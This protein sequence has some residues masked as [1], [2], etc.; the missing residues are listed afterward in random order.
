MSV[1]TEQI[2][3]FDPAFDTIRACAAL[4]VFISHIVIFMIMEKL[5]F[6]GQKY[7]VFETLAALSV[8]F[9][10]V[11]SGIL[12]G[13]ILLKQ[14]SGEHKNANV[15]IFLMRRWMRTLPVYYL[16]LAGYFLIFRISEFPLP[17]SWPLY[18]VFLQSP[19]YFNTSFFGVSW[20][21]CIEE[22]FYILF[23]VLVYGFIKLGAQTKK[24]FLSVGFFLIV[25]CFAARQ[26]YLPHFEAWMFDL[27][28]GLV[29][30]LDSIAVGL[31]AG[32]VFASI[33]RVAA[34][35][36]FGI[37]AL[38]SALWIV[39]GDRFSH[40]NVWDMVILQS[41]FTVLPWVCAILVLYLSQIRILKPNKAVSF[42]ADISYGLYVFHLPIM[43][44]FY[45]YNLG[46]VFYPVFCLVFCYLVF[47]YIETPILKRRPIYVAEQH[48]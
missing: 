42:F 43:D 28:T 19:V 16:A 45:L 6:G 1:R 15:K 2:Q 20:S 39:L 26:M 31:I 10:F 17:D 11:L 37:L 7:F 48:K 4:I 30:R 33:S 3:S 25:L 22:I 40:D 13:R 41:S 35:T 21:L 5:E 18:F 23:P 12:L 32:I 46:G 34:W 8:E 38:F 44:V 29:F 27:R 47:R 14:F 36:S 9:F 24:A